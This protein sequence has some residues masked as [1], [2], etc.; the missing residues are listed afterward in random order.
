MLPTKPPSPPKRASSG[1][2]TKSSRSRPQR[3]ENATAALVR[4][5]NDG[6]EFHLI[7]TARRALRLLDERLGLEKIVVEGVSREEEAGGITSGL[8]VVD[9]AEYFGGPGWKIRY[10][11]LKY[12]TRAASEAWTASGLRETL[13]GFAKRFRA[14]AE[15]HG[16]EETSQRY[17]F[18]FITNR[19]IAPTVCTAIHL[20]GRG[21][22]DAKATREVAAARKALLAALELPKE[23]VP[24]FV[25]SLRLVG[26]QPTLAEQGEQL[27]A[28]SARLLP[29]PDIQTSAALLDMVR[30]RGTSDGEAIRTITR[31]TVLGV[32]GVSALRELLPAPPSIVAPASMQERDEFRRIVV[33]ILAARVPVLLRAPGG[34]GKSTLAIRLPDLM[35]KGSEAVV[36]DGFNGGD[37]RSLSSSRHTTGTAALQIANELAAQGLC[38]PLIPRPGASAAAWMRSLRSRLEQAVTSVRA[39]HAEAVVL[40]V[41][42]AGDNSEIAA[43]ERGERS[44]A[45]ELLLETIPE[46]VRV[47]VTARPERCALLDPPAS[48]HPVDLG[49]FGGEESAAHLRSR[50]PKASDTA[51]REFHRLTSGNP[52]VQAAFIGD[53]TSLDRLFA[54]L[55]PNPLGAD[56]LIARQLADALKRARESF[57]D[58]TACQALLS[59]LS[60]LPPAV[61]IAT[62]ARAAGV[63]P[64]AIRSFVADFAGGRPVLLVRDAV[65]FRDEPTETWFREHYLADKDGHGRLADLLG[66]LA[67]TDAYAALALPG[68][69]LGAGRS[70]DLRRLALEAPPFGGKDAVARREVAH[71]RARA[72]LRGAVAERNW[73][74]TAMLLLRAAEDAANRER[75]AAF[76]AANADLVAALAGDDVVADFVFRGAGSGWRGAGHAHAAAMLAALPARRAEAVS[77]LRS[78]Q[79]WL[80]EWSREAKAAGRRRIEE[81]TDDA[82]A[83][84]ILA[85]LEIAGPDEAARDLARWRPAAFRLRLARLIANRLAVAG[86]HAAVESLLASPG[87]CNEIRVACAA[88]LA[89]TGRQVNQV[90]A[91]VSLSAALAVGEGAPLAPDALT[92]RAARVAAVELAVR[93][94]LQRD[95]LVPAAS[96]LLPPRPA[97][98][99]AAWDAE[100]L[101]CDLR[102]LTLEAALQGRE[103]DVERLLPA[104]PAHPDGRGSADREAQDRREAEARIVALLPLFTARAALLA[105][106][107]PGAEA[108]QQLVEAASKAASELRR[109]DRT[110]DRHR[111]VEAALE[112]AVDGLA[113]A[114][115]ATEEVSRAIASLGEAAAPSAS[116]LAAAAQRLAAAGMEDA[117]FHVLGLARAAARSG[118]GATESA[119]IL[120]SLA[121]CLLPLS[122]SDAEAV[123]R[124]ANEALAALGEEF[125]ARAD[126]LLAVARRA[127]AGGLA[128][129]QDAQRLARA[130]EFLHQH[131]D[132]KFPWEEVAAAMA[133]LSLPQAIAAA[134]RWDD[135]DVVRLA[136]TLP[137]LAAPALVRG[138]LEPGLLGV[139][140]AITDDWNAGE[141][142]APALRRAQPPVRKET[143]RLLADDL[144]RT[145]GGEGSL[146]PIREAA[147]EFGLT[148][149]LPPPTVSTGP[150]PEPLG[151]HRAALEGRRNGPSDTDRR[152]AADSGD[153]L[154][155][156]GVEAILAAARQLGPGEEEAVLAVVRA[157]L[158]GGDVP[159]HLHAVAAADSLGLYP[160]ARILRATQEERGGRPA[161]AEAVRSVARGMIAARPLDFARSLWLLEEFAPLAGAQPAD[162]LPHVLDSLAT[163]PDR[164][165]A[166]ALFRLAACVVRQLVT[167]A[168]ATNVMRFALSRVEALMEDGFG[169]G[170]WRE[171]L[172]AP[173]DLDRL[174]A[175]LLYARLGDPRGAERWRAAHAVR[176][177]AAMGMD[178]VLAALGDLLAA[179]L[180]GTPFR[181]D[182]LA[183]YRLHARLF[184][185]VALA[186]VALERPQTISRLAPMLAE[187][188]LGGRPHL[189]I[190]LFAAQA[191]LAIGGLPAQTRHALRRVGEPKLASVVEGK[192]PVRRDRLSEPRAGAIHLPFDFDD[193]WI[194]PLARAFGTSVDDVAT[195]IG[196]G[197]AELGHPDVSGEW[198]SDGRARH[199]LGRSEGSHGSHG[200][201]PSFERLNFYLAWHGLQAAAAR[202][203][204]ERAPVV[205]QEGREPDA[206]RWVRDQ[207]LVSGDGTWLADIGRPIPEPLRS[208]E[209]RMLASYSRGRAALLHS[210][211]DELLEGASGEIV[212][213][214]H[215]W[216]IIDYRR[217]S[218]SIRSSLVPAR[219]AAALLRAA[220]TMPNLNLTFLPHDDTDDLRRRGNPFRAARLVDYPDRRHGLDDRDP[221]AGGL[222]RP[223]PRP[224]RLLRGLLRPREARDGSSWIDGS[225]HGVLSVAR[226]GAFPQEDPIDPPRHGLRLGARLDAIVPMLL[227]ADVCLVLRVEVD[228]GEAPSGRSWEEGDGRDIW[229]RFYALGGDGRLRTHRGATL[230]LGGSRS[231]RG[232]GSGAEQE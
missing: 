38:L 61:P 34:Y 144:E 51:C 223:G 230:S 98:A 89:G 78:A 94:S 47:V 90:A 155:R 213:W 130:A 9:T 195:L 45:R 33:E 16:L 26:G 24:A 176:R 70:T 189:L 146:A 232:T 169:E 139:L 167:P 124:E 201:H 114:A 55:G 32:L 99:A 67:E 202:L 135:R 107:D 153:P 117:V 97:R 209:V 108:V 151:E 186:R 42:D 36:Y 25:Q 164:V 80:D 216:T 136:R 207:G 72:A 161:V 184:L 46:G 104:L 57:G 54:L 2:Q 185:L 123:F 212:V 210:D 188:A 75:Q 1:R 148:A 173:H 49:P 163:G 162:L 149:I 77:F 85:V 116:A 194:A 30:R 156:P 154:A 62:L 91:Q 105:G 111:L 84:I 40:V 79:A 179:D 196:D 100:R 128:G 58:P 198:E 190:S 7:W 20:L 174:V 109:T 150:T 206:I 11:Q 225:G 4:Y 115:A 71:A 31:E 86:R 217:E 56:A 121:R 134:S 3:A 81:P 227:R 137:A 118:G 93:S 214:G 17:R 147:R 131:N 138:P 119:Y 215:G 113:L 229:C 50:F 122:R 96:A 106:A 66:P 219:S 15:R 43:R 23:L 68:L 152:A 199:R 181:S 226:W 44:F 10:C 221:F 180:P 52:R 204:T 175:G 132:H 143:I 159:A 28:E 224:S 95:G 29:E 177:A 120:A 60:T 73:P 231:G 74:A 218:W 192:R 191:A 178:S 193:Y 160:L 83:S 65:Q 200:A 127:A 103:P 13:H 101:A 22:V 88:A 187:I 39:R 92:T 12:S 158:V 165:D 37:Y 172:V 112:A 211:L 182:A 69:L 142:F 76:L 125:Y 102:A 157:G 82:V 126:A 27:A 87:A 59:A 63:L 48:V 170:A 41:V 168:E 19:P 171:S 228:R 129:Q 203:L 145:Q 183:F 141:V 18:D 8:L 197:I 133:G 166:E 220:Q 6:E 208:R 35:P 14:L 21:M 110:W 140:H 205:D 53:A 64:E 222:E 5:R